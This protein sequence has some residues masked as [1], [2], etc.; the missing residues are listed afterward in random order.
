[1]SQGFRSQ[2]VQE[3]A[4]EM[5]RGRSKVREKLD[6]STAAATAAA[7]SLNA[8][9]MFPNFCGIHRSRA[10]ARFRTSPNVAR[11]PMALCGFFFAFRPHRLS[12]RT[13]SLGSRTSSRA[14]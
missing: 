4:S 7:A 12:A 8:S 14:S 1:M 9:M 11:A 2:G 3:K 5:V 6:A 10:T 13:P